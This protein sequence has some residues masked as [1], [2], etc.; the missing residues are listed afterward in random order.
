MMAVGD[1]AFAI[2]LTNKC[3]TDEQWFSVMR[4]GM[5][6]LLANSPLMM[7]C[8]V[9]RAEKIKMV[10]PQSTDPIPDIASE[11]LRKL[12]LHFRAAND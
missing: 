10:D 12:D 8:I 9:R 3:E 1:S 2:E 7:N 11:L 6:S 5:Q 4:F